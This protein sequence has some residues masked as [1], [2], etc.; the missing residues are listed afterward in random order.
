[1][2][3]YLLSIILMVLATQ[4]VAQSF[5]NKITIREWTNDTA[6]LESQVIKP[7]QEQFQSQVCDS[8]SCNPE[9]VRELVERL[10]EIRALVTPVSYLMF[11]ELILTLG[12]NL[13]PTDNPMLCPEKNRWELIERNLKTRLEYTGNVLLLLEVSGS[14]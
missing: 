5:D 14:L 11:R 3:K 2:Q 8:G 12:E 6:M 4:T 9:Y 7:L 10:K 13:G 1:M